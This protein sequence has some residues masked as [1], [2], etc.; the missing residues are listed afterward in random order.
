MSKKP[1]YEELEQRVQEFKQADEALKEEN[2]FLLSLI[3]N[4]PAFF[5]AIDAQGKTRMMN[6]HMLTALD[7]E[8]DE[9]VGKDYLSCFVPE[10][11]RDKLAPVFKKLNIEHE[12]ARIENHV[13]SKDG[14][15]PAIS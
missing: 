10:R 3:D 14:K 5:V 6:Q 9:V 1:T 12:H 2:E 7:Y 11:D 15:D 13:V 4:A 8:T